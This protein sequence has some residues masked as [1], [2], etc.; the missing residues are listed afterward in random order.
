MRYLENNS[1]SITVNIGA[2]S[3]S[4]QSWT[5]PSIT[6]SDTMRIDNLAPSSSPYASKYPRATH[7]QRYSY[8]GGGS[9]SAY[10]DFYLIKSDSMIN[11]GG[12]SRV[13]GSGMDTTYYDYGNHL[14]ML[15]PFT[16]GKTFTTR[17]SSSSFPGMYTV[18]RNTTICDAFGTIATPP[19]TFQALRMKQTTIT[20]TVYPGI[21]ATNDTS[22]SYSWFSRDGF[23]VSLIPKVKN[24]SG[25]S[26]LV[27]GLA[28][29]NLVATGIGGAGEAL[30]PDFQLSQNY[31]NP[32]NPSTSI[33]YQLPQSSVVTLKVYD[34]LGKEVASLVEGVQSAGRHTVRFDASLLR[35]G[36]Y[37]Y[38]IQAGTFS[39]TKKLMVI[40]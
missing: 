17:D 10:Y 33:S 26:I 15:F 24:P 3:S 30:P 8:A 20:Q 2:P 9:T 7:M 5:F 14:I 32:F 1:L 11:L 27:S 4:A 38:R 13:Q 34:V 12:V 37:F 18:T 16:Y 25:S 31:P 28:Y 35:S 19:G 40:K 29:V 21:P 6:Y 23:F 39:D 22:V 36:V